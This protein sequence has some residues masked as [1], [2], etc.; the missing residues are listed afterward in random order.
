MAT[1]TIRMFGGATFERAGAPIIEL[2]SGKCQELFCY[3]LLQGR[4]PLAREV[5]AS[6]FWGECATAQ[7]RKYLRQA[8][9][10]LQG[11]LDSEP[12]VPSRRLLVVD[13]DTVGIDPHGG[14]WVDTE[15][16]EQVFAEC[17]ST[18]GNQ[19]QERQFKKLSGAVELYRGDLLQGWYRDWCLFHRER[20]QNM[21]M[22]MLDKLMCY[23]ES[24][25]MYQMGMDYG[26]RVLA[27]D[28]AHERTHQRMIRF[29]F[30]SGDRAGALRQYDKCA[31]ALA[32]ELDVKPAASTR[33]LCDQVRGDCLRNSEPAALASISTS[34][35]DDTKT[36]SRT[37]LTELLS[38]LRHLEETLADA[39]QR[40]EHNIVAV[41][42]FLHCSSALPLPPKRRSV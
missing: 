24:R 14:I 4:R 27:L 29:I 34:D 11:I 6:L 17:R 18:L 15:A 35:P 12:R 5:L 16:F 36:G 23:C 39:H 26:E 8:L 19:L 2:H 3:L 37:R 28:R 10:Q 32:E 1:L 30:L 25:S 21:Y 22:A 13:G 41:E 31:R 7:S 33:L 9:W 20:L 40:L 42:N 38:R